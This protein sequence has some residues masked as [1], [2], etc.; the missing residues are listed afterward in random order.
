MMIG[1]FGLNDLEKSALIE[2]LSAELRDGAFEVVSGAHKIAMLL[3][4][5]QEEFR[6]LSKEQ[7]RE[8]RSRALRFIKERTSR[9][10]ITAIVTADCDFWAEEGPLADAGCARTGFMYLTH[11]IY[12]RAMGEHP[13]NHCVTSI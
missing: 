8:V 2:A 13:T 9:T 11:I 1:L 3:P 4:N 6:R 7:K 12:L 10:N 5:G